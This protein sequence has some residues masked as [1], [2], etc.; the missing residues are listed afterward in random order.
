MYTEL[1]LKAMIKEDSPKIVKD[2]LEFLF[3]GAEEPKKKPDHEFFT[4]ERWDIIGRCNSYYHVPFSL[5][6]YSEGYVFSRSD[7]KNY[8]SE[9]ESFI[10]WIKPYI[11]EPDGYCIGWTWYE[12]YDV[13]T[14]IIL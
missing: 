2:I 9:I 8:N 5:S 10:D 12:E 1:V 3:N 6:K 13:P 4:K 7:F 11:D 14:L